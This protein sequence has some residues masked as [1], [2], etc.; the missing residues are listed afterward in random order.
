MARSYDLVIQGGRL[1]DGTGAKPRAIDIA[2]RGDTIVELGNITPTDETPLLDATGLVVAPGFIDA[3]AAADPLAPI[4][5]LA[6]SK[7]LQGVTTEVAGAGNLSPF[8]LTAGDDID[9]DEATSIVPDWSDARG[10]LLR[11][12]R[13]GTAINRAFYVSY[14]RIRRSIIGGSSGAPT[15]D[16][17]QQILRE[18]DLALS[19]GCVGVVLDL[20]QPPAMFAST[21]ELVELARALASFDAVLAVTLR[22]SGAKLESSL[23]EFL[24]TVSRTGVNAVLPS[25]HVGPEPYWPLITKLDAR[26]RQ[27]VDEGVSLMVT[28]EPYVARLGTLGALLP[29]EIRTLVSKDNTQLSN[30][31]TVRS[32]VIA[33]LQKMDGDDIEFWQRVCPES[34][35]EDGAHKF[36]AFDE[37]ESMRKQSFRARIAELILQSP[38]RRALFYESS[39]AGIE[40]TISWDF[41]SIGT[42]EPARNLIHS[43]KSALHPRIAGTFPRFLRRYIREKNILPLEEAIRRMTSLPAKH[44]RLGERGIIAEGKAADMVLFHDESIAEKSTYSKPSHSPVGVQHVIVAGRFAVRDGELTGTKVGSVLMSGH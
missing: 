44:L 43:N 40:Q 3:W 25:L 20:S 42:S 24:H 34:V 12:A 29:F 5:P 31:E 11:V 30:S 41:T 32:Q 36:A 38:D 2:I 13:A 9:T 15:R 19:A 37:L 1:Y 35:L 6:E 27:A 16:E 21:E 33:H 10:F 14:G 7:L 26:L 8:P 17:A 22:N 18:V 4:Y 28:V 39:E 23:D